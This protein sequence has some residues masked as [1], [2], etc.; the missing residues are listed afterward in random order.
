MVAYQV[1]AARQ[2]GCF[3]LHDVNEAARRC[4]H[5]LTACLKGFHLFPLG[6]TAIDRTNLD[7]ERLGELLGFKEDL[8]GELSR[9]GKNDADGTIAGLQHRLCHDVSKQWPH[10][11]H[12]LAT[13]SLGDANDVTARQNHGQGLGLDGGRP[14]EADLGYCAHDLCIQARLGELTDR[15][16]HIDALNANGQ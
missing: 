12:G 11:R 5:D 7:V 8:M 1:S 6:N 14:L 15:L 3:R 9:W 16:C 10:K 2:V 4:D 13:S